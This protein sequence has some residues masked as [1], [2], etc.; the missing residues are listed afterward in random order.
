MLGQGD[1]N[2][3]SQQFLLNT[4]ISIL[5]TYCRDIMT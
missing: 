1:E 3:M 4:L 2:Q 5:R